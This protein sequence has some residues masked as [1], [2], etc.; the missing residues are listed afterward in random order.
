MVTLCLQLQLRFARH[1]KI[2]LMI[3]SFGTGTIIFW[4][5]YVH[6][7]RNFLNHYWNVMYLSLDH[8][9]ELVIVLQLSNKLNEHLFL[10]VFFFQTNSLLFS[11]STVFQLSCTL[12]V[13]TP[14]TPY[15]LDIIFLS[16]WDSLPTE[17]VFLKN[18]SKF[19]IMIQPKENIQHYNK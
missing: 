13:Q 1:L 17:K 2:Y 11:Y 14:F 7:F 15:Y 19:I 5:C 18:V 8:K 12:H 16:G 4:S 6:S 3:S 9:N 10:Y